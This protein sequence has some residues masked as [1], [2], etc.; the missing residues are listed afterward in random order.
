MCAHAWIWVP[1]EA[2]ILGPSG[3]G[4]FKPHNIGTE[5]GSSEGTC[6][7]LTPEPSHQPLLNAFAL[8]FWDKL[9]Y[10]TQAGLELL[11]SLPQLPECGGLHRYIT[12]PDLKPFNFTETSLTGWHVAC[13]ENVLYVFVLAGFVCQLDTGWSYHRERNFSWGNASMR[14]SCKAF[15]QLVIIVGDTISGLGFYKKTSWASQGKQ[16]SK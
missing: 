6:V 13:F 15:S 12:V 3:T 16:A 2:R 7:L 10:V 14:S 5:L 4:S 1:K 9:L 11:I 8:A